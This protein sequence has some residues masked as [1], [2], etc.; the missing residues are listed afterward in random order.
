MHHISRIYTFHI[1]NTDAKKIQSITDQGTEF[2]IENKDLL[3]L[4][5]ASEISVNHFFD[6]I[7]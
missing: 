6:Q 1:V 4:L 7:T 2:P 3:L 5:I